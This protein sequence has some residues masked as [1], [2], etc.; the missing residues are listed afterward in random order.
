METNQNELSNPTMPDDNPKQRGG[1][2][3]A[4]SFLGKFK[5]AKAKQDEE[6]QKTA[7][8]GASMGLQEGFNQGVQNGIN[9]VLNP[10][11]VNVKV[12]QFKQSVVQGLSSG[13]TG[14][15]Q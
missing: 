11:N 15:M 6:L 13:P 8:L 12:N 2:S 4:R 14:G 5:A 1:M 10:Q 9:Q 3:R 7:E